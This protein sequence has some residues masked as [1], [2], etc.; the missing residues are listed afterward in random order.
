MRKYTC[1]AWGIDN[2]WEGICTSLDIAAQGSSLEEVIQELND[3][4]DTYV[5]YV[6]ELP[7]R[8]RSAL[9]NRRSP[10]GLRVRL[11]VAY[12]IASLRRAL[13]LAGSNPRQINKPA[14][15]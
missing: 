1:Y 15:V 13:R 7:H 12:Q 2:Q 5:D 11:E 3:A 10:F 6:S 14:L 8:E 9:L 4:V